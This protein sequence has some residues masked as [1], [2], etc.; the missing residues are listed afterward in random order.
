[1]KRMSWLC[2]AASGIATFFLLDELGLAED[3]GTFLKC[4]LLVTAVIWLP[5]LRDELN[6]G[7]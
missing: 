3:I 6:G 7:K 2:D 4:A 1:M 5:R